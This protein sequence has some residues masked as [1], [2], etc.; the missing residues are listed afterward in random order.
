MRQCSTIKANGE[1]CRGIP[2][3]GAQWCPAHHPD[4]VASRREHGRKGGKR[5]G[6]GRP[7]AE[8]H[9]LRTENAKLRDRMIKGELDPRLV[10]VAVQSINVDTRCVD[11]LLRAR[12][13][14][15]LVG[16][17]EEIEARLGTSRKPRG[18]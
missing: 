9:A 1:R 5:G 7:L 18:A 3:E 4:Y 10:A 11:V 13:Q 12:E 8:L 6:R 15:E 17:M 16:R 2:I 14:E